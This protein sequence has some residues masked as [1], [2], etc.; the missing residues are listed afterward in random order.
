MI[1]T[2]WREAVLR[3]LAARGWSKTDLQEAVGARH[4]SDITRLLSGQ[5]KTSRYAEPVAKVLDLPLPDL[6]AAN[7]READWLELGAALYAA[8]EPT[9]RDACDALRKL[10]RRAQ[11]EREAAESMQNLFRAH[12]RGGR[13]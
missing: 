3:E 8:S 7:A 9:Y 11:A 6:P 5:H 1:T 2:D 10:L 13:E 4:L 12:E